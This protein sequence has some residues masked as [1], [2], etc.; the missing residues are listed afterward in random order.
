MG[1][2]IEL[3]SDILVRDGEFL[4][5]E[6]PPS[7]PVTLTL[8]SHRLRVENAG[9]LEVC[10]LILA[11]S[12]GGSAIVSTGD[13]RAENCTFA[14]CI[15]SMSLLLRFAELLTRSG[16][17]SNHPKKGAFVGAFGGAVMLMFSTARLT[18]CGVTFEGNAA[19]GF[20]IASFG[21]AVFALGA[22]V[23]LEDC[24]FRANVV[25]GNDR[26]L[27]WTAFGGALSIVASQLDMTGTRLVANEAQGP[28][29]FAFG[30][31]VGGAQGSQL[32]MSASSFQA[33]VASGGLHNAGGSIQLQEA[34]ALEMTGVEFVKNTAIAG[35]T[36][37]VAYGGAIHFQTASVVTVA[38]AVFDSNRAEGG[39]RHARGGAIAAFGGRLIVG[40]EVMF[41]NNSVSTSGVEQGTGGALS[42]N[43]DVNGATGSFSLEHGSTFVG[44]SVKGTYPS[45]GALNLRNSRG[46]VIGATFDSNVVLPDTRTGLGGAIA[47]DDASD[48]RLESCR[49]TRNIVRM[50]SSQA[51]GVSGGGVSVGVN[52]ALTMVS[53]YL[54]S[55]WAGGV[56][57]FE[58]TG[59]CYSSV[60]A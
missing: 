42:L 31:A 3:V 1:E 28:A 43:E 11:D 7:A 12:I 5:V 50:L 40:T 51:H 57:L 10:A 52:S 8:R 48:L 46:S 58:S 56:G 33:N 37:W 20:G 60:P 6:S 55:N 47:V 59:I 18:S 22:T 21:G 24:V 16:D 2:P 26:T 32:N 38:T 35:S 9:K 13:V 4:R 54:S 15:T 41:R 45:G 29:D 14:R 23:L 49:I 34:T 17:G 27:F 53:V 39:L 36:G 44:N 25:E 19:S 30:G